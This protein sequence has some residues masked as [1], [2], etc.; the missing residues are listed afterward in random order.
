MLVGGTRLYPWHRLDR[1][2]I[3]LCYAWV[4]DRNQLILKDCIQLPTTLGLF[5]PGIWN[6]WL[7][8]FF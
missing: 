2:Q 6:I 1:L 5:F 4:D 8:S 7:A 3:F